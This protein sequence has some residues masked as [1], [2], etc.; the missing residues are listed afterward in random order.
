MRG[1]RGGESLGGPEGPREQQALSWINRL[2]S[3]RGTAF[4]V[5]GS[6]WSTGVRLRGLIEKCRS[7]EIEL[8][9]IQSITD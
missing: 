1:L 7:G 8:G 5:G 2:G 9:T 3:K 6:R 4:S